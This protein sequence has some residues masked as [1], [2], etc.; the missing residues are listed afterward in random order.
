MPEQFVDEE[1]E[2]ESEGSGRLGYT[3]RD[4]YEATCRK[5]KPLVT[6]CLIYSQHLLCLYWAC[7]VVS[8]P[9]LVCDI[10]LILQPSSQHHKLICYY[11]NNKMNPRLII[12]PAKVEVVYSDPK[13]YVLRDFLSDVE[14]ERLIELAAPKVRT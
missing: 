5:G 3:E 7:N 11:F 12:Q 6:A 8:A 9:V 14:M 10:F 2:S 1:L 13:I 4:I